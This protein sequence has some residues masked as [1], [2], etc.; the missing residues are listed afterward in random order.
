VGI[1][2]GEN[3]SDCKESNAQPDGEFCQHMRGLRAK[4]ILCHCASK[5]SSKTLAT[6]KLHQNDQHEEQA[7]DH[8]KGQ[9]DW[10]DQPHIGKSGKL[11]HTVSFVKVLPAESLDPPRAS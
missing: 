4:N 1:G 6:R 9:Q 11:R 2:N 8:V 3:Q 10:D 5:R 7:H